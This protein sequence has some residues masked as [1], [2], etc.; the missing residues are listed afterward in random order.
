MGLV[1]RTLDTVQR[2]L[3]LA[4][5]TC[6]LWDVHFG[7]ATYRFKFNKSWYFCHEEVADR[8]VRFER[9][10]T[11][12]VA[13]RIKNVASDLYLWAVSALLPHHLPNL[14]TFASAARDEL[15]RVPETALSRATYHKSESD[16]YAEKLGRRF[17]VGAML[18][19]A[20]NRAIEMK[21]AARQQVPTLS[22]SQ[23]ASLEYQKKYLSN[24]LKRA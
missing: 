17:D 15:E 9:T 16:M 2:Q 21:K 20:T 10:A 12:Q 6:T 22:G 8:R 18:N 3:L 1:M 23:Q 4:A 19:E 24:I 13:L 11:Y 7:T 14:P 5:P